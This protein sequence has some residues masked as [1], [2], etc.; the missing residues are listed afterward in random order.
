MALDILDAQAHIFMTI[1]M[2]QALACMDALGI[3]SVLI[4]EVWTIEPDGHSTPC[5]LLPGGIKR[6]LSPMAEAASLKYPGRFAY[7]Q[8]L[9][10]RDPDLAALFVTLAASPGCRSV[11]IDLRLP[12]EREVFKAGGFD[13]LLKL[14][15]HHGL[16]VSVLGRDVGMTL[17]GTVTRLGGVRFIIDHCGST[18]SPQQWEDIL[19]L[20]RHENIWMKWSAAQ[21]TWGGEYPFPEIQRQFCRAVDAFGIDH[22][23]WATDFTQNQTGNCWADLLYYLRDSDIMSATDKEWFFARSARTLLEWP[24]LAPPQA[25]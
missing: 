15:E 18:R 20:G 4:D 7:V 5:A 21:H 17:A 1:G 23:M 11:R 24:S 6:P 8:R 16:P 2:D 3:N 9:D 14:A 25:P 10:R 13:E 19:A 12:E 22:L